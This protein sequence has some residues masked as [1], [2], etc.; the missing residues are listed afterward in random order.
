LPSTAIQRSSYD[1]ETQTLFVTFIDG[2]L[3]A[4]RDVEAETYR[5]MRAA[6]SKGRFFARHIRGRY[7][8]AKLDGG[9]DSVAFT[10]PDGTSSTAGR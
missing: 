3:Y 7:A 10:R 8:Y 1:P 2:D 9:A 4:Y 5:A 6:V